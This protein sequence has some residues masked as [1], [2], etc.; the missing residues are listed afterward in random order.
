MKYEGPRRE[1]CPE[2][3]DTVT[4]VA[5]INGSTVELDVPP[6]DLKGEP[7]HGLDGLAWEMARDLI[8]HAK[9]RIEESRE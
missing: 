4:L 9:L 8:T 3:G 7:E 1:L 6:N 5:K 2:P